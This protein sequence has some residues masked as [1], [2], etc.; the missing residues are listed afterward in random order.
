VVVAPRGPGRHIG[1][2]VFQSRAGIGFRIIE[3]EEYSNRF[4]SGYAGL[5]LL[6]LRERPDIVVLPEYL[7]TGFFVHP[8]LVL[9]RKVIGARLVLKSIPFLLPDYATARKRLTESLAAPTSRIGKVLQALGLRGAF[10][11]AALEFRA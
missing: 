11:R 4:F 9:A 7:L 5:P 6:L 3:L 10:L 1:D 2:G 8:G